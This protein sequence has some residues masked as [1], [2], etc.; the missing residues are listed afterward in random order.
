MRLCGLVALARRFAGRVLRL[1]EKVAGLL[2]TY[3]VTSLK[4]TTANETVPA[5][6][7]NGR[8]IART[9]KRAR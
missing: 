5:H 9:P 8:H 2:D 3:S 6:S 1:V 4:L 7:K